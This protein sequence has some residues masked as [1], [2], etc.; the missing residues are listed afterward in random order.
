MWL[1]RLLLL[2]PSVIKVPVQQAVRSANT[3]RNRLV[4]LPETVA[5]EF[6]AEETN[7]STKNMADRFR[8][9]PQ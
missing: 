2:M 7:V 1:L 5:R 4:L 9:D 3:A 8:P 6:M